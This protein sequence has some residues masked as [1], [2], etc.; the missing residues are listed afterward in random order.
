LRHIF[1]ASR[2]WPLVLP[3][4]LLVLLLYLN[5][6]ETMKSE[7]IKGDCVQINITA[8]KLNIT[9][10]WTAQQL[11]NI[12]GLE[13]AFDRYG[14]TNKYARIAMLSI[15]AKESG[16]IPK[17]ELGYGGTPNDRIRGIW[18][19]LFKS[20]PDHQLTALKSD[21]VAF[22]ECVYGNQYGNSKYGDGYKYRGRGYNQNTFFANYDSLSNATGIDFRSNPDKM[23]EPEAAALCY[24][25]YLKKR[26]DSIPAGIGVKTWN[27]FMDLE[28]AIIIVFRANAGWGKNINAPAIKES[29]DRAR[30]YSQFFT[31]I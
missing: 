6:K 12:K 29:L 3:L 27:D 18:P 28:T 7:E 26:L 24:M 19:S 14:I 2:G 17:T 13:T 15:V 20:M 10:N 11:M 22:F 1:N 30:Y 31:Y 25:E 4:L 16:F 21:N 5:L 8:N 23:N 9:G